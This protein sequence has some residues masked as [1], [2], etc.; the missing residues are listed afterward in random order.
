MQLRSWISIVVA[1]ALAVVA[2]VTPALAHAAASCGPRGYA[3]AGL[4]AR[5]T[6]FGVS[7]TLTAAAAPL[8]Q[9]G[10][11][12]GWVGVGAPGEGPHDTDEWLQIGLNTIAGQPAKLY[13]ETAQPWG[14]RYAEL[15][16]DI[17]ASRRYQVAVLEMAHRPD[18]WRVWVNGRPA[19]EPIWLPQ[20][21]GTLTAMAIA[22]SWDGG[23]PACN[24]Y[25]YSFGHVSLAGAPGGSWT[26]FRRAA[27]TVMQDPGSRVV[28]AVN[29][30]VA[31]TAPAP[32]PL[33]RVPVRPPVDAQTASP[34]TAPA[35]PTQAATPATALPLAQLRRLDP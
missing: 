26:R 19:S 24:R 11:V 8:V 17:P 4:Q 10:H 6:A 25:E 30:F 14:I 27:A 12:A 9:S 16:S 1:A 3:Y 21:H 20:S 34:G 2:A 32:P 23:L 7:A 22:E 18:V 33:P 5:R 31:V 15:A 29:G 13:Y 35:D 28:P